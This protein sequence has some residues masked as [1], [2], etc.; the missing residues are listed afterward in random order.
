MSNW[1]LAPLTLWFSAI[2]IVGMGF[3]KRGDPEWRKAA[4]QLAMIALFQVLLGLVAGIVTMP[5]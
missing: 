4:P 2:A 5:Q 1:L 3:L